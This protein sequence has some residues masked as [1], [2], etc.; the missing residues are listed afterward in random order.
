M[1]FELTMEQY[2]LFKD[3]L[4]YFTIFCFVVSL[5]LLFLFCKDRNKCRKPWLYTSLRVAE[6]DNHR[7]EEK[8]KQGIDKKSKIKCFLIFLLLLVYFPFFISI[9]TFLSFVKVM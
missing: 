7:E 4:L 2:N 8:F 3:F 9:I 1:Y 6:D 5:F